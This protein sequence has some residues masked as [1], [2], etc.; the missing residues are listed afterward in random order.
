MLEEVCLKLLL[1]RLDKQERELAEL[2]QR[3]AAVET[4]ALSYLGVWQPDRK[5]RAGSAVTCSGALWVALHETSERPGNGETAWRL[6]VKSGNGAA[7]APARFPTMP[8][9]RSNGR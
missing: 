9:S 1:D 4:K 3:L 7:G 6:A 5:Y 8:R 2:K